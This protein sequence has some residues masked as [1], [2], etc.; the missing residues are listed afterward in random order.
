MAPPLAMMFKRA[1]CDQ[2]FYS[3]SFRFFFFVFLFRFSF[4]FFVFLFSFFSPSGPIRNRRYRVFQL[5]SR[6]NQLQRPTLK[7][8]RGTYQS[9]MAILVEQRVVFWGV[10]V[11]LVML[12]ACSQVDGSTGD[13]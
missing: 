10:V 9:I 6:S 8:K 12:M 4:S 13:I 11:A 7:Q 1:D 5:S 3:H 2:S